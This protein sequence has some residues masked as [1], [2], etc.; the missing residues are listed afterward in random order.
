MSA[1]SMRPPTKSGTPIMEVGATSSRRRRSSSFCVRA[2]MDSR[3]TSVTNRGSFDRRI[4]QL[5]CGRPR[6][7]GSCFS[8][9]AIPAL[10]GSEHTTSSRRIS[11]CSS[12]NSMTQKSASSRSA[13]CA[14]LASVVRE[15][16]V[17]AR[18]TL[19]SARNSSSCSALFCSVMSRRM[20]VNN[21]S[22]S[23]FNF[24]IAA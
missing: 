12:T 1:P 22:P 17:V 24:E 18:M 9:S 21:H 3:E 14:M 11:P 15:S 4:S 16:S 6:S 5:K 8:A 13:S 7:N 20:T 10:S 19:A 23:M 2:P